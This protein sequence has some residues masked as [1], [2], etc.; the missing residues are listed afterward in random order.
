MPEQPRRS[1]GVDVARGL[2]V[3]LMIQTHA[4]DGWVT[5]QGKTSLGYQLSRVF[6]SVPAPLFLFLAGLGLALGAQAQLR[7][8]ANLSTVRAGLLG[9]ALRIAATGYLLSAIY[10]VIEWRWDLATL[11]RADILHAIGLSLSTCT[12]LLIGTN[13][14]RSRLMIRVGAL[15]VLSIAISLLAARLLRGYTLPD[16][17]K[18]LLALF[19]DVA[20]Y[21][22]F[23]LF[24]LCAFTAIGFFVGTLPLPGLRRSALLMIG[25][26]I[27]VP[28]WRLLTTETVRLVGGTLSRGHPAVI[29]NVL[30]GTARALATLYFAVTL[31]G[32]VESRGQIQGQ[33]QGRAMG[34]LLRLGSGSLLA[35][36]LHIPLC[37][38]RLARP[39]AGRLSMLEATPLV[40]ALIAL[41]VALLWARDRFTAKGSRR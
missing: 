39:I 9:R 34:W 29:W 14:S 41:M 24:P 7:R 36:A 37:Y 11:L 10:S 13:G 30:E 22:R 18:P 15:V 2:A 33:I 20:P 28:L 21:S 38:G 5:P 4:Y 3:I 23:P 32:L 27:S 19:V 35:Y 26:V 40:L 25:F 12:A 16:V 6:A 8:G 31:S 1:L 17:V